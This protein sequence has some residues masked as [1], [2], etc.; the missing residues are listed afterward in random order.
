LRTG[1]SV[2]E[3][4]AQ[5]VEHNRQAPV[6]P[7]CAGEGYGPLRAMGTNFEVGIIFGC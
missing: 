1:I 3:Q 2:E 5:H 7:I 4:A 6:P